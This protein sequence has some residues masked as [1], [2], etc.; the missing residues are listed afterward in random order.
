MSRESDL[1]KL[2]EEAQLARLREQEFFAVKLKTSAWSGVGHGEIDAWSQSLQAIETA[3][4]VLQHWSTAS[5]AGG[6]IS[7]YPVFRRRGPVARAATGA[8]TEDPTAFEGHA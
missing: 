8:R 7:A 4:W 2:V 3:G 5:D 1:K 6:S